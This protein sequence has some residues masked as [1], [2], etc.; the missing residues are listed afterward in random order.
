[1]ELYDSSSHQWVVGEKMS[2]PNLVGG[3]QDD[4]EQILKL[5]EDYIEATWNISP[6]PSAVENKRSSDHVMANGG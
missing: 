2:E 3:S 6:K 4:R 5:H 1:M